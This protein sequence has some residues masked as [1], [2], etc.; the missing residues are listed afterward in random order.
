MFWYIIILIAILVS[1]VYST[2]LDQFTNMAGYY[3]DQCED[4]TLRDCLECA[5]CGWCMNDNFSSQ[6]VAGDLH[7]A[8]DKTKTCNKWYHNDVW[9]RSVLANDSDYDKYNAYP[10]FTSGDDSA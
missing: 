7:G 3:S 2:H 5:N 6:C 1:L 9:T 8:Y 10:I 4:K